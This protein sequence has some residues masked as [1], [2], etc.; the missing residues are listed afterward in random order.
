MSDII[1]KK[2]EGLECWKQENLVRL[3]ALREWLIANDLESRE[4]NA[5]VLGVRARLL[6]KGL[7]IVFVGDF[8]KGKSELINAIF[9]ANGKRRIMPVSAGRTTMCT[10]EMG[11]DEKRAPCIRLLPLMTRLQDM[12]LLEW[13]ED[14]YDDVWIT[15]ELDIENPDQLATM[16]KRVSERRIVSPAEAVDLGLWDMENPQNNPP[17][18]A[19]GL[20]EV[21][22]WRYAM[23]NYPHPLLK[24]GISILDTP[25]LNAI[26][27][28]LELT[29]DILPQAH[30]IMYV[31]QADTGV[32]RTD[33]QIWKDY[34]SK[35]HT[36][37]CPCYVVL[38]KID[39]LWDELLSPEEVE[40]QLEQQR[41]M[42]A[43][44]LNI[45]LSKVLTVSAHK[46]LVGKV[47]EDETLLKRSK[48][49][50]VEKTLMEEMLPKHEQIL[51]QAL[52]TGLGD[53]YTALQN[54][55]ESHAEIIEQEIDELQAFRSKNEEAA[56]QIFARLQKREQTLVNLRQTAA[57]MR[58]MEGRALRRIAKF[59]G[60]DALDT[61]L[62]ALSVNINDARMSANLEKT[63]EKTM[64]FL[65]VRAKKFESLAQE[66]ETLVQTHIEKLE[67]DF[68]VSLTFQPLPD[69][70]GI[71]KDLDL[72][73]NRHE[74][75]FN[76][77]Q[78]TR[79]RRSQQTTRVYHTLLTRI[80][81]I[82]DE[83]FDILETWGKSSYSAL[84]LR[85]EELERST[86]ELYEN[87]TYVHLS[88]EPLDDRID[89]MEEKRLELFQLQGELG[90]L[91]QEFD[92]FSPAWL[93]PK[94]KREKLMAASV[95]KSADLEESGST[96][97]NTLDAT[98]DNVPEADSDQQAAASVAEEQGA[99][100][101]AITESQAVITGDVPQNMDDQLDDFGVSLE[102]SSLFGDNRR[103]SEVEKNEMKEVQAGTDLKQRR[104]ESDQSDG[105]ID[106][107]IGFLDNVS[108]NKNS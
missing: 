31:L 40:S 46:G 83:A 78:I 80:R 26:G 73:Q 3:D 74:V 102:L 19:L 48:L 87:M 34:L 76:T 103:P 4:V 42:C 52:A 84:I 11:Y 77:E 17:T 10:V 90:K 79:L 14:Q 72:L 68:G 82:F 2:L 99:I 69:V 41:Q 106:F 88:K 37:D 107:K 21:P 49:L 92:Q 108:S 93:S 32:M 55:F 97:R 9:F 7:K 15:E 5:I 51:Q 67:Q 47:T 86:K 94:M 33:M 81:S 105:L 25:G 45:P 8:S 50:D 24:K 60:H 70:R 16:I 27:S 29:L 58:V 101:E 75:F 30:V 6:S 22:K 12:S 56:K 54:R 1:A 98:Q 36:A 65:R 59:I 64:Y 18:N 23:I 89:E 20:L 53:I 13:G 104:H 100:Q 57:E 61:E 71:F 39:T 38:N 96:D 44:M 43:A 66:F 95:I 85:I 28:E 62:V 35:A 91:L 63:F